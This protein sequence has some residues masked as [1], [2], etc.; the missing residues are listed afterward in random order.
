MSKGRPAPRSATKEQPEATPP[1]RRTQ[2][3]RRAATQKAL[4]D[5]TI[6]ALRELGYAKT[7]TTE[8]VA[9]AGVSQGALFKYYPTKEALLSAAAEAL[10]ASLFPRFRSAMKSHKHGDDAVEQAIRGLWT[11]FKTDEVRVLHELYAAAPKE[12]ALMNALAPVLETHQ[13]NILEQSRAMFPELA[14][15]PGFETAVQLV[16]TTMT[17]AALMLF[18]GPDPPRE[19]AQLGALV[20]LARAALMFARS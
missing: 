4:L 11:V 6:L 3:E 8:I 1:P 10:C 19:K 13:R 2:A 20:A 14:A 18:A 17:G 9:R 7:T 12:P 16:L 15:L 5:A